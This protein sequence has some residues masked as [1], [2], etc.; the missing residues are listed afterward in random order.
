MKLKSIIPFGAMAAV[1]FLA[2]ACADTDAQYAIPEVPAPQITA[3]FPAANAELGAPGDI[4]MTVKYDRRIFFASSD[5][6][7]LQFTGGTIDKAIVYGADSVLTIHATGLQRGT[8]CQLTIPDGLV[9][10]PNNMPAAGTTLAFSVRALPPVAASPVMATQAKAISLYNYLRE[11]YRQKIISGMMASVA[12]NNDE[13]ELVHE[14]TGKYPAINGYDYIHLP[15]SVRGANWINYGDITPVQ[16]WFDG[17]GII[18]IGWHWMAPKFEI[19]TG[20]DGGDDQPATG[21]PETIWEGQLNLGTEWGVSDQVAADKFANAQE[22]SVMT[23]YFSENSDAT[24]WQIKLMD[25]TWKELSSYKEVDNGWGCIELAADA[26]HYAITLNAAD[27]ALLK[28]GGMVMSG[29]GITINKITLA[30]PAAAKQ[31]APR[32]AKRYE[33]L[34]PNTDFSYSAGMFDLKAAVTEGTWQNQ[35]VKDD[36]ARLATYLKLLRDAGIPV[37]WRPLH[38]ASGGWFWWGTDAESF[39]KLW[40]MMFDYFKQEGLNNLIWVWTSEGS[41]TDWYPGPQY[42]DIIGRDLYGNG[43]ASCVEEYQKVQDHFEGKIITLSECGYSQYTNSVV[44]PIS[45]QWNAGAQWS[46]FMPWYGTQDNGTE[47]IHASKEWWQDAMNCPAVITRDQ[48]K[49]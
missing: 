43:A 28:E 25:S 21:E 29:Y 38:E 3:T 26:N 27:A 16:Q 34:D 33:D 11:N 17:G 49:Y 19:G 9:T 15:A 46:W 23:V 31:W 37:L 32:R 24:Y 13:S 7:K 5:Y 48:V 39:K 47:N 44:A 12:W 18:N 30:N 42:V 4:T 45:E 41:D 1:A 6:T 36:L 20:D 40:I 35:F 22:G 2:T 8:S 14:M 10:G